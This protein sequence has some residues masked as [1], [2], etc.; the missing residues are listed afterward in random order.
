M[1]GVNFVLCCCDAPG[2][3]PGSL[4]LIPNDPV[5]RVDFAQMTINLGY[6]LENFTN[7]P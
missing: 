6:H 7:D 5:N 4:T 3:Q 2:F 1:Q